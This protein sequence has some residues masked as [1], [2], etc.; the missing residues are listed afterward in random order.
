[1]S[2]KIVATIIGQSIIQVPP[3]VTRINTYEFRKM[4]GRL[5]GELTLK[6]N[7]NKIIHVSCPASDAGVVVED[8]STPTHKM[9][10]Q[11]YNTL[12]NKHPFGAQRVI[13]HKEEQLENRTKHHYTL[14]N[15]NP[16]VFNT[17]MAGQL[18]KLSQEKRERTGRP[19]EQP[20]QTVQEESPPVED[21][22]QQEA[23]E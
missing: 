1:M 17:Q 22:E 8:D 20:E 4:M 15:E 7:E 2:T 10:M 21:Q 12:V 11:V 6:T 19:S 23:V 14:T 16:K 5:V 3:H 13:I 9:G 18:A